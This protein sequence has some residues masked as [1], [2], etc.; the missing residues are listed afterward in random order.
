MKERR[1]AAIQIRYAKNN[2]TNARKVV[3]IK[4][5]SI[6]MEN[7]KISETLP[8]F[9][10]AGMCT[11]PDSALKHTSPYRVCICTVARVLVLAGD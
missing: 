1:P 10:G 2:T 7:K 8:I 11:S 3:N 4:D 6:N 9:G 5:L